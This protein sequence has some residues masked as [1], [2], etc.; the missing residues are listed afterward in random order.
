MIVMQ[1]RGVAVGQ[2]SWPTVCFAV[3]STGGKWPADFGTISLARLGVGQNKVSL[4]IP[5]R[6]NGISHWPLI[7]TGTGKT[8]RQIGTW[9]MP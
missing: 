9:I 1:G 7:D 4:S 5:A 8:N 3:Q 6:F 2:E